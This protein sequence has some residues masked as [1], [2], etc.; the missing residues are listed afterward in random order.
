M[1]GSDEHRPLRDLDT[2]LKA[3]RGKIEPERPKSETRRDAAGMAVGFRIAVDL[4]AGIAVGV[5]IGWFLDDL[6]DTKPWLLLLFTLVGFGAG[7]LNVIR[8]A[9]QFELKA[10]QERQA[11]A[12]AEAE[13]EKQEDP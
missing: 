5:G 9:K 8:T 1:G 13:A 11:A 4:V 6:L 7:L 10:E 12:Q 2:R 3:A